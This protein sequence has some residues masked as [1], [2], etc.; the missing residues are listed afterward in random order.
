LDQ[1]IRAQEERYYHRGPTR[2]YWE[3]P[4]GHGP[5]AVSADISGLRRCRSRSRRVSENLCS[6][7]SQTSFG[8][9][10]PPP[11]PSSSSSASSVSGS[12]AHFQRQKERR[13]RKLA[14]DTLRSTKV[15]S[16][17]DL[18]EELDTASSASGAGLRKH[19][20]SDEQRR[21][22]YEQQDREREHV[23]KREN[24]GGVDDPF[25]PQ[26]C[27][28]IPESEPQDS[29]MGKTTGSNSVNHGPVEERSAKTVLPGVLPGWW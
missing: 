25:P 19:S 10:L 12:D 18:F 4:P 15:T 11:S 27:P 13:P 24:R 26:F 20:P 3:Y 22:W 29:G 21:R 5:P 16:S 9:H 2:P 1:A 8:K 23:T 28:P 14:H 17:P 7:F 6:P